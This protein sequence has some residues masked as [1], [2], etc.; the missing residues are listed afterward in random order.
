MDGEHDQGQEEK[1][2]ETTRDG[3]GGG[4]DGEGDDEEGDDEGE[5]DESGGS[6]DGDGDGGEVQDEIARVVAHGERALALGASLIG[7]LRA[8]RASDRDGPLFDA[9]ALGKF[10]PFSDRHVHRPSGSKSSLANV[11]RR[12]AKI[13]AHKKA[14]ARADPD[15]PFRGFD[16]RANKFVLAGGA[17]AARIHDYDLFCL[18]DTP[19]EA[20]A[21]IHRLGT[22]M[23]EARRKLAPSDKIAVTR[24]LHC[25]TFVWHTPVPPV[26]VIL[27]RY[28]S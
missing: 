2:E 14:A 23:L 13:A 9:R 26:Q 5:G 11:T 7:M 15:C 4:G 27:R 19:E 6:G 1:E 28:R 12:A 10:A 25:V 20:E 24:T 8:C 3:D 17:P 18:H 16:L 22:H 21:A